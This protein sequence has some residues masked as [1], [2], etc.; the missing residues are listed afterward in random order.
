MTRLDPHEQHL[1]QHVAPEAGA[2]VFAASQGGPLYRA[3]FHR[4]V[5]APPVKA[6]GIEGLRVHD[7]RQSSC[8]SWSP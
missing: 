7:L 8:R 1:A 6:A 5:W 2:L 3:T 4:H